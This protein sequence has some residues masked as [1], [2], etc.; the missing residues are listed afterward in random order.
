MHKRKRNNIYIDTSKSIFTYLDCLGQISDVNMIF[1]NDKHI[2]YINYI[3]F[4]NELIITVLEFTLEN[5][6][7]GYGTQIINQLFIKYPIISV[8]VDNDVSKGFWNKFNVIISSSSM[9][10]IKA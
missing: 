9:L 3:E 2:G 1:D 4:Q 8:F 10:T 7:K 6:G 5:R